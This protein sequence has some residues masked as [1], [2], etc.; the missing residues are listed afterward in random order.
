[1]Q[2]QDEIAQDRVDRVLTGKS[3]MISNEAFTHPG[4]TGLL[5]AS[6]YTRDLQ[7]L[8]RTDVIEFTLASAEAYYNFRPEL[9]VD[10]ISPRPFLI[11]HGTRETFYSVD[12]AKSLYERAKEPKELIWIEGGDHLEWIRP[13]NPLSRPGIGKVVAWFKEKLPP[14]T[15]TRDAQERVLAHATA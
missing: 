15:T 14:I 4:R 3:K 6:Q 12:E 5:K 11:V 1:M 9:V 13:E 2:R 8:N 10:K 7:E